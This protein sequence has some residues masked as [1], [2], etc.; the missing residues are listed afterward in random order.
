MG[1]STEGLVGQ[2]SNYVSES[3]VTLSPKDQRNR[4]TDAISSEMKWKIQQIPGVKVRSSP[5]GFF[6]T[7]NQS[8]IMLVV[9]GDTY[10]DALKAAEQISDIVRG[11]PGTTD[12][13]LSS[14][15]G[16]PETRIEIDREKLAKLGL[17]LGEVGQTLR[18]AFN[19][20]DE[21]KFRE[22]SNDYPI[23]VVLDEFDRSKT[24]DINNLTFVN[25]RGQ[26]IELKQFATIDLTTGPSKLGRQNRNYSVNV[27]SQ[28][29]GRPSGSI[30]ADIKSALAKTQLP[31]GTA[32]TYE[33]D[34]KN[35]SEGFGSRV[36]GAR[37]GDLVCLHDH[38]RTL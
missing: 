18:I 20:D 25:R 26:Q 33:G 4:S 28:V 37:R 9:S 30:V 29:V 15:E 35:R 7:A 8:P 11:V 14:E 38:G 19:G 16:K 17:T 12:V 22:G 3:N 23:R 24:S 32:V 27:L 10:K 34:E 36:P 6:G 31:A 5:I 13:R 21:S 1:V 2:S